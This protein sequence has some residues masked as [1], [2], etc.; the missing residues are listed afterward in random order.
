M[1]ARLK[2]GKTNAV[3]FTT[4]IGSSMSNLQAIIEAAFEKRAEITPKNR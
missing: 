4:Y 1:L 2:Y 3:L